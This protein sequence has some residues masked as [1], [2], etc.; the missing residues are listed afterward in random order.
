MRSSFKSWF[1]EKN[2][3]NFKL[4]LTFLYQ[5]QAM[6]RALK[7]IMYSKMAQKWIG[8]HFG[9]MMKDQLLMALCLVH[10]MQGTQEDGQ[11]S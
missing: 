7:D 8:Y 11:E 9:S 3:P 1:L 5:F 10:V 6:I 2:G 4:G